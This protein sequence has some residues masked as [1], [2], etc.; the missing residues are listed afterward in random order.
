MADTDDNDSSAVVIPK[1]YL[2]IANIAKSANVRSLLL[3]AVAF[4]CHAV[5]IV[6]QAKNLPQDDPIDNAG[7][8][9][10]T[11][12]P[13]SAP[14]LERVNEGGLQLHRFPKWKDCVAFL[15]SNKIRLIGVEI[16]ET[17]VVLDDGYFSSHPLDCDTALV[18]GNEGS[19]LHPKYMEA[20]D[21]LIMLSQYGSGT[22]SF[23][24]SI[25][26]SMVLYRFRQ[27]QERRRGES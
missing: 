27:E 16:D 13:I 22:A 10:A 1:T 21:A 18:M 15:S 9:A 11:K 25:A 24:V 8:T 19:G 5:L 3:A 7:T 17:S 6:G 4:G 23:N 26:A 20:C 12:N 2:V 14:V